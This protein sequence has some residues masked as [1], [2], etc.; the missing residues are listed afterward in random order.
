[1]RFAYPGYVMSL[2]LQERGCE[3]C[4]AQSRSPDKA[5]GR[6]RGASRGVLGGM[7]ACDPG[8]AS[9]IRA[10]GCGLRGYLASSGDAAANRSRAVS[11]GGIAP[12]SFSRVARIRPQAASGGLSATCSVAC[13][14]GIPD[15]LR[16]SGLRDVLALRERACEDCSAVVA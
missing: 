4:S 5:A 6:I 14:R 3:D 1:M 7:R 2:A 11:C 9:L 8:C 12:S 13:G 16:L 10:T 15:A